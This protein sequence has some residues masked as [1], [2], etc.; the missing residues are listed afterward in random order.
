EVHG[1]VREYAGPGGKL[2]KR[3]QRYGGDPDN[4]AYAGHDELAA[5]FT[6]ILEQSARVLGPGGHVVVTARPYR[7][8]GELVDIPGLVV[9]AG[10]HAGLQLV[11][12]CVALIAGVRDGRLV[13]RGSFFQLRNIREARR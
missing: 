4:L 12:R 10:Q 8:E 9:A 6:A 7:L 3:H 13:P 2:V 11:E 5:G 1:H